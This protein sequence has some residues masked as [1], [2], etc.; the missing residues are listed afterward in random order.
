MAHGRNPKPGTDARVARWVL[1]LLLVAGCRSAS[2]SARSLAAEPV[3]GPLPGEVE[4]AEVR[5]Q[6]RRSRIGVPGRDGV[7]ERVVAVDM[8]PSTAADLVQQRHGSRYGFRRVDLGGASPVSVEL[9]GNAPSGATVI[10]TSSTAPPVLLYGGPDEV[11]PLPP[12]LVTTVV[13]TVVSSQ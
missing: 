1:L 11:R 3:L 2:P 8:T 4:L 13:T 7:V 12:E 6:P 9:R 10:I 5:V